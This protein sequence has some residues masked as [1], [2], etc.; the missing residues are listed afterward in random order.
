[1]IAT[2]QAGAR[3]LDRLVG[4]LVSPKTGLIRRITMAPLAGG[5][6]PLFYPVADLPDFGRLPGL[7]TIDATGGAAFSA[8]DSVARILF[9]TVERYCGAFIDYSRMIRSQPVSDDFLHGAS[10]P[11]FADWQYQQPGWPFRPLEAGSTIWWTEA[12]SLFTGHRRLVPSVFVHVPYRTTHAGE[13]LG[14]SVSTGMAAGWSWEEACLSG[15]LEVCERDAFTIMW[16]NSLAMPRILVGEDSALDRDLKRLLANTGAQVWFVN[17]TSDL[18]IPTVMAVLRHHYLGQPVL[19]VGAAARV[20]FEAA[21]YKALA[22][23]ANGY[24]RVVSELDARGRWQ[25]AP[26]FTDVTDFA[27]H[28]LVYAAPEHQAAL[29]FMLASEVHRPIEEIEPDAP[30]DAA[31]RLRH[32]LALLS[33]HF[34]E[35]VAVDLTTREFASL[36]LYAVKVMI[37]EAVPLHPDHRYPWL[38]HRRLYEVPARLG[39]E[40]GKLNQSPHPFS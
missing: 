30:P 4:L 21:C 3:D 32:V 26:G 5:E 9:E 15:L 11:L 18:R 37:P 38:G 8:G 17:V 33:G 29:D 22:E 1:M 16:M 6:I 13:C 39:Y 31:G 10:F 28:S 12:R 20:R 25:P 23:A 19:T 34:R 7:A 36:G 2:G 35:I 14:P 27:Y 40:T 24:A